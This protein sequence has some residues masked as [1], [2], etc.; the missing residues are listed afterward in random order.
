PKMMFS[1][2]AK[3][4]LYG[5]ESILKESSSVV[6]CEGEF[7]RLVLEA[8]GFPAVT[9]TAGAGT[10]R[11]EWAAEFENINDVYICFDSDE[12]GRRGATGVGLMI[13]HAKMVKLPS[14]VGSKGDITDFFVDLKHS[15]EDFLKLLEEAKPVPPLL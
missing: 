10:F 5:W 4:E 1:A 14:E 15:R 12:A 3:A 13:P 7:D 2:G 6:I 9:S 11:P 8:Q